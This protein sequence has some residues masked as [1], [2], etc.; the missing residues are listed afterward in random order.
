MSRSMSPGS[1]VLAVCALM[2]L[3]SAPLEA[4]ST[5]DAS[6]LVVNARMFDGGRLLEETDVAVESGTIRAGG[7]DLTGWERLAVIDGA[8][9]TVMPGLID[10]HAHVASIADPQQALQF[11]VTT[12]LDMG[13]SIMATRERRRDRLT[14]ASAISVLACTSS[15]ITTVRTRRRRSS[16]SEW[17]RYNLARRTK[18]EYNRP[19]AR[20]ASDVRSALQVRVG[21][22]HSVEVTAESI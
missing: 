12:L 18:S 6:F 11:A 4:Q 7:R 13:E 9:S 22:W 17:R 8:N 20:G 3:V 10:A 16:C 19:D 15:P 2:A 21:F 14:T 1:V 5:A